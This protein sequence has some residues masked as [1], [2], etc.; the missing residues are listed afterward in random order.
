MTQNTFEKIT[1][2]VVGIA[3]I[4]VFCDN[5]GWSCD[6][7]GWLR[8]LWTLRQLWSHHIIL[9][10][11]FEMRF[12]ICIEISVFHFKPCTW[13]N[14]QSCLLARSPLKTGHCIV[15]VRWSLFGVMATITLLEYSTI[16]SMKMLRNHKILIQ[17]ES[18]IQLTPYFK[19]P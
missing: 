13:L 12:K 7:C 19:I 4:V 14:V 11:Y 5:C 3:T 2:I 15:F 6:N 10:H 18:A 1:T 9:G 8:Q 16:S 17:C